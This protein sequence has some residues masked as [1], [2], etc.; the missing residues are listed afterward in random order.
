M[1][2]NRERVGHEA[3]PSAAA[4]D[5][6]SVKTTDADGRRGYDAGKKTKGRKRHAL[7]DTDGRALLLQ[8]SAD[9]V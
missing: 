6:Q 9:D 7:V 2:L 5:S 4:M 3:M 1:I 8:V